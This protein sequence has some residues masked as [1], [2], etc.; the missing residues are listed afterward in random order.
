[1]PP[2]SFFAST[3]RCDVADS[4]RVAVALLHL[5]ER[6][7]RWQPLPAL[8]ASADGRIVADDIGVERSLLYR[9]WQMQSSEDKPRASCHCPLFVFH[10][11]GRGTVADDIVVCYVLLHPF[12]QIYRRF[13]G[14]DRGPVTDSI[15]V[16]LDLP[17]RSEE[18]QRQLPLPAFLTN[19]EAR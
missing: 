8:L 17:P 5:S 18:V 12:E 4:I 1:M 15:G 19:A 16:A 13:P 9:S 10:S 7:Q 3:D 14:T 6:V 11:A 2:L